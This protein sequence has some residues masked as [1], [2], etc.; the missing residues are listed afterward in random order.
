MD[1]GWVEFSV[2]KNELCFRLLKT[3]VLL[4]NPREGITSYIIGSLVKL[5]IPDVTL[6]LA[7]SLILQI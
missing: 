5:V 2:N 4:L 3:L 6:I 7:H 1:E